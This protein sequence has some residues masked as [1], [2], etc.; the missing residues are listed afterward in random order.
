MITLL[1]E[2]NEILKK[3]GINTTWYEI[4]RRWSETHRYYHT[5]EHL[6]DILDQINVKYPTPSKEREKL[7]LT[8]I[9]HDIVYNPARSDNEK[10]SANYFMSLVKEVNDDVEDVHDMIMD[11]Q[12]HKP[13]TQLSKVFC[14]MDMDI[15]KRDFPTLLTWEEEI[16]E[17]YS[18][19]PDPL[20]KE[21]RLKFLHSLLKDYKSNN[22]NLYDLIDYVTRTYHD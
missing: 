12:N 14:D 10:K 1:N 18:I 2:I 5:L 11:T 21:H 7:I 15:V 6:L 17:E 16:R 9:F 19:Y 3:W 22:H 13:S 20:Y 4:S 8:A